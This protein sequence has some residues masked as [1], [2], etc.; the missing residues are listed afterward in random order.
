MIR[1]QPL[2]V[3][4]AALDAL[5]MESFNEILKAVVTRGTGQNAA[6]EEHIVAGKTGTAQKAIRGG[7][8]P[9][10]FVASFGGYVPADRPKLVILVAVDEPKGSQYGGTIAAPVFKEIAESTLRYLGVPPSI[11]ARSIGVAPPMLAAFS[12]HVAPRPESPGVPEFRGLDA[13]AAVA[14]AVAAGLIVRVDGSGVV[15]SQ[16]PLPGGALPQTR[17]ISLTLAEGT[18]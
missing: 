2:E 8:S 6:L 12:Q 9:D 14:R 13:R 18:R 11:P 17:T 4:G 15:T 1:D 16:E 7:Y 5:D 3:V 10:R